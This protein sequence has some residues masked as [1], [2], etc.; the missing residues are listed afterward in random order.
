M[1]FTFCQVVSPMWAAEPKTAAVLGLWIPHNPSV[2]PMFAYPARPYQFSHVFCGNANCAHRKAGCPLAR[3]IPAIPHTALRPG[4]PMPRKPKLSMIPP[5]EALRDRPV[6]KER[7]TNHIAGGKVT[8]SPGVQAVHGIIPH[9]HVVIRFNR[10][11]GG[12][13]GKKRCQ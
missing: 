6:H 1:F 12:L 13:I 9:Y 8:P 3:G 10:I 5:T 11:H 7:F 2:Y 4:K